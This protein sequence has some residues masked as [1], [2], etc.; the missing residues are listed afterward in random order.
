MNGPLWTRGDSALPCLSQLQLLALARAYCGGADGVF[1][2]RAAQVRATAARGG[3]RVNLPA[4]AA[5]DTMLEQNGGVGR[6]WF[7]QTLEKN[8]M[9]LLRTSEPLILRVTLSREDFVPVRGAGGERYYGGDQ[10]WAKGAW[11]LLGPYAA[12]TGC[13][14]AAL[15]DLAL[16]LSG[17]RRVDAA[18]FLSRMR[19]ALR[20]AFP[21]IA[22]AR[23]FARTA[24][25]YLAGDAPPLRARILR[26]GRESLTEALEAVVLSLLR[27]RPAAMQALRSAHAKEVGTGRIIP[28]HWT[29]VC[30]ADVDVFHPERSAYAYSTWGEKRAGLFAN[31]WESGGF[32]RRTNLVLLEDA[33]SE[34]EM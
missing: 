4:A 15:A 26:S 7:C 28:W 33:A 12:K 21:P 27:D 34:S 2:R 13:G 16:Y 6:A 25:R 9:R 24:E 19:G 30:E 14:L 29:V 17:A 18:K 22:T 8:G 23:G 32:L 10:G 11:P 1:L 20:F 5:L 31:A 3:P